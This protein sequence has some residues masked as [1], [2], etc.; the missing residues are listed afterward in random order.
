MINTLTCK[1][2]LAIGVITMGLSLS[3]A[4]D[5]NHCPALQQLPQQEL[6]DIHAITN[7]LCAAANESPRQYAALLNSLWSEQGVNVTHQPVTD[8]EGLMT[9]KT[10]VEGHNME[11][12]IYFELMPDYRLTGIDGQVVGRNFWLF[13]TQRGTLADGTRVVSPRGIQ[14]Q[15]S[16]GKVVA[17]HSIMNPVQAKVLSSAMREK[18][19]AK[20]SESH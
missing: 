20:M 14:F 17:L 5:S 10:L 18:I 19:A 2:A 8:H 3:V 15:L 7:R 6:T 13:Y 12:D 1:L 16:D 11:I 4:A 9:H